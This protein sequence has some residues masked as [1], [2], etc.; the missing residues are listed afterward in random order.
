M[1][2]R[3]DAFLFWHEDDGR[4]RMLVLDRER[5]TVGRAAGSDVW[6]ADD[7]GVSRVHATLERMGHAWVVLDEG[8]SAN[9]TFHNGERVLGRDR[10]ADGDELRFGRTRVVFRAP[11]APAVP[12]TVGEAANTT[13]LSDSQRRVL[14]AL[15]RPFRD[16]AAFAT[17]ATNVE[18]AGEVFLGVDAVKSQLRG[19]FVKFGLAGLPQTQK[20]T[21]LAELAFQSGLVTRRDLL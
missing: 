5:V 2:D 8:L 16:G 17:P 13:V 9:G 6:L 18:I 20:R 12:T 14:V 3:T 21:R 1:G 7:E 15:C 19:L 10:L 4:R 11:A